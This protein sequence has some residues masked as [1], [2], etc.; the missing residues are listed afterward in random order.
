MSTK[1]NTETLIEEI[2]EIISEQ[3]GIDAES[4]TPEKAF[5]EDLAADSL[6]QTELIM[7]LEEKYGLEIREEDAEKLKKVK[8]V[9]SYIEQKL[10]QSG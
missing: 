4:V 2:I 8:D 3:L 9:I 6:D 5:G 1:N 7:A 10:G